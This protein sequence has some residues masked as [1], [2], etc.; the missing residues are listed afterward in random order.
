MNV[1]S[2]FSNILALAK[3]ASNAPLITEDSAALAFARKSDRPIVGT[4]AI[5]LKSN[6]QVSCNG[7]DGVVVEGAGGKKNQT[8]FL[9]FFAHGVIGDVCDVTP[10]LPA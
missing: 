5:D 9:G 4:R 6:I 7:P 10:S 3:A 8:R 1:S 2:D